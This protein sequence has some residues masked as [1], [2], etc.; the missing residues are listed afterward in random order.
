MASTLR[1]VGALALATAV[2]C[3]SL[4]FLPEVSS[5]LPISGKISKLRMSSAELKSPQM[6]RRAAM[7]TLGTLLVGGVI[8]SASPVSAKLDPRP[9]SPD[10][11]LV[12]FG[13][14]CFWHVQVC[15]CNIL[16]GK[17]LAIRNE[18]VCL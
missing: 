13:A 6:D 7:L 17:Y 11:L 14:G 4:N 16:S 1:T 5:R 18:W 8:S 12:Y 10:D 2:E 9:P 15:L 3:F